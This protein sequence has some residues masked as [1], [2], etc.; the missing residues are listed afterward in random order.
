MSENK[1]EGAYRTSGRAMERVKVFTIHGN[2]DQ[3]MA[4]EATINKWIHQHPMIDIRDRLQSL[5]VHKSSDRYTT[6]CLVI[7]VFYRMP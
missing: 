1:P 3:L 7:T 2:E 5:C 4:V 6:Y